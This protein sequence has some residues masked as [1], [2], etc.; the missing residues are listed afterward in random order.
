M[1]WG[2]NQ[3][4]IFEYIIILFIIVYFVIS[5]APQDTGVQAHRVRMSGAVKNHSTGEWRVEL[6]CGPFTDL[7]IPPAEAMWMVV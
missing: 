1:G 2:L 6:S 3:R 7:G 5:E 4:I